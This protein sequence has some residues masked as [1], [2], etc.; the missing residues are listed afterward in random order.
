MSERVWKVY[1]A[2]EIHTDWRELDRGPD[3]QPEVERPRPLDPLPGLAVGQVFCDDSQHLPTVMAS[4]LRSPGRRDGHR[5]R[6]GL[7]FRMGVRGRR[8]GPR[9]PNHGPIVIGEI[10]P[11]GGRPHRPSV[12]HRALAVED[13]PRRVS[14]GYALGDILQDTPH[15]QAVAPEGVGA[16]APR[17]VTEPDWLRGLSDEA[18]MKRAIAAELGANVT[19]K[20]V[21]DYYARAIAQR[22]IRTTMERIEKAGAKV[23]YYAVDVANGK[24]VANLL[25]QVQVKHGAITGL[26]H[27]A[28]V[29]ADRR[30]DDLTIEQFDRVYATKVGGLQ[31]FLELLDD[32]ELKAMILFSSTTARFGRVGQVAYA[33]ANE[34]LNKT[35]A[36]EARRRPN[37]RVVAINWGPWDGGMVTPGPETVRVW[38][39]LA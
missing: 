39:E 12:A 1:L 2:G 10:G 26:V 4:R 20:A 17:E 15:R 11:D 32:H 36:V 30:I 24:Q 13:P 25:H 28:G 34:V 3:R 27:G 29:L 16:V 7:P 8:G 19:P 14:P 23:A 21:G 5:D 37:A 9:L 18:E 22:Q 31:N 33:C 6:P 35:A 38:K